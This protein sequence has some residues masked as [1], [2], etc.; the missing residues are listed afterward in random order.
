MDTIGAIIAPLLVLLLL[1][2]G[3]HQRTLIIL[4]TIPALFALASITF[5]VKE[6]PGR[7]P[8]TTPLTALIALALIGA[9]SVTAKRKAA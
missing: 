3:F 9:R 7:Q 8:I 6:K 2:I 4:S 1:H 5:L